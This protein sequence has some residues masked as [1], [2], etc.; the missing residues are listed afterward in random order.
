MTADPNFG[1]VI[2]AYAIALVI[3]AGMI[4]AIARDYSALKRELARFP[5][6]ERRED[7]GS[8]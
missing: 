4:F 6:R 1:F 3:V 8:P 7:G 2:A 5:A